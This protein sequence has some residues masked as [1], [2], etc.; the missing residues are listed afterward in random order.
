LTAEFWEYEGRLG[1]RWNL[2]PKPNKSLSPYSV[3]NNNPMLYNDLKGD[4]I[5]INLFGKND[6]KKYHDLA[7]TFVKEQINDGVFMVF[8]HGNSDGMEKGARGKEVED[9]DM[10]NEEEILTLLKV[11]CPS[12]DQ[13]L[14]DGSKVTL[15]LM[16]CNTGTINNEKPPIAQKIANLDENITVKA[17]NGCV[18]YGYLKDIPHYWGIRNEK[19]NGGFF[20]FQK[21]K[22]KPENY[23]SNK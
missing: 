15:V 21:K 12:L 3:L 18:L 4:T 14:N 10:Y 22:P 1:R 7:N 8:S 16:A 13:S 5:S 23:K 6:D 2:D 9:N 11:K 20:T 19:L 17:P